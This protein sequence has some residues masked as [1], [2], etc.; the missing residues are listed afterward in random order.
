MPDSP[1]PYPGY[2]AHM[3][4]A[5]RE[6]QPQTP[7]DIGMNRLQVL[8]MLPIVGDALGLAGDAQMYMEKPEERTPFNFALTGL[9]AL[10]FL[11]AMAGM[12]VFHGTP[13]KFPPVEGNP[14]GKF[15]LADDTIGTG[16]GAQAYGHGLYFAENPGVARSYRDTLSGPVAEF[17]YEITGLDDVKAPNMGT[18]REYINNAVKGTIDEIGWVQDSSEYAKEAARK[19]RNSV[20]GHKSSAELLGDPL[21]QEYIEQATNAADLLDSGAINIQMRHGSLYTADL[22]DEA[23][24]RMLDWDAPL[25]DAPDNVRHILAGDAFTE[26]M[27]K[28][29]AE[30]LVLLAENDYGIYQ[31]RAIFDSDGEFTNHAVNLFR[32][33]HDGATTAKDRHEI[34]ALFREYA[35]SYIEDNGGST[36]FEALERRY[37]PTIGDAIHKAEGAST[38]QDVTKALRAEGIPGIKYYD[39]GSRAAGEGTRNFVVFDDELLT[40]TDVE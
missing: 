7:P 13:H 35:P 26:K 17:D 31:N 2:Y 36:F 32:R 18:L 3:F 24:D 9:G 1:Q 11:P 34:N 6:R 29:L 22:P 19:L 25:M 33:V 37:G 20:E 10:P 27:R 5:L 15:R 38:P 23:I 30:E 4:P 14:L 39:G 8:S 40:I 21:N 28:D 12:K 16:E